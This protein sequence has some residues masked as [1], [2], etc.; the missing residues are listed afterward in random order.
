MKIGD[1]KSF[2]RIPVV[3]GIYNTINFKWYIGSCIDF[4]DRFERHRYHLRHNQ[5]HSSKL[6]RAYNIYGED[7]FDVII[8]HYITD[9]EDRFALEQSYIESYNSV[10]NGY[11]MLEKCIYVDNFS[12]SEEAKNNFITYIKTLKKS[13]VAINRFTGEI[14][15]TFNSIREA[16][17]Y[18][19]TSTSNIS[20]TCKG[21]FRHMKDRVFVYS[22][23]FD[24]T[25]DY[26]VL[27][28]SLKGIPKSFE[29]ILKM[30]HSKRCK[31]IY[32]Y[33]TQGNFICEYFSISEAARQNN[34]NK[35]YLRSIINR[36]KEIE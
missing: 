22:E 17:D 2:E 15:K 27:K 10:E 31:P 29:Q 7:V 11:N 18:Y 34:V 12:L 23:D 36:G 5:H 21:I 28:D 1:T 6:Q 24:V 25:K 3:Y 4:K 26:R 19:H 32:K 20:R 35:D 14:D 16:A 30:R 8:L 9:E 33:D 13:V